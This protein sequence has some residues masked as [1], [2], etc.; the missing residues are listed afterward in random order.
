[1]RF[2]SIIAWIAAAGVAGLGVI[3]AKT[4]PSQSEYEDYAVEQLTGYLKTHVCEKTPDFLEDILKT[5]TKCEKFLASATPQMHEVIAAKTQKQDFIIFSI[6]RTD[7][8]LS[9]WVPAYDFETVGAFKHFYTYK[10]EK[11]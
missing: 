2:L 8:K 7:L 6:Y 1:M 3:M 9:S 4:N 5:K 10:A 11:E